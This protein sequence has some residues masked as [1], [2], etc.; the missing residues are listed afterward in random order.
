MQAFPVDELPSLALS[1]NAMC[2]WF[3]NI[4]LR[5]TQHYPGLLLLLLAVIAIVP[6]VHVHRH[7]EYC[8]Y[9]YGGAYMDCVGNFF[10]ETAEYVWPYLNQ[11]AGQTRQ[12]T[13]GH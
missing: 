4:F 12:M 11:L 6:V 8:W 13:P 1:Y 5:W 10:G 3:I 9:V 2:I 7:Q